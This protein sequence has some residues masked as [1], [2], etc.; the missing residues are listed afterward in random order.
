M[1]AVCKHCGASIIWVSTHTG[2]RLPLDD[3]PLPRNAPTGW[4]LDGAVARPANPSRDHSIMPRYQNHWAVC[5]HAHDG[6]LD[7]RAEAPSDRP[8]ARL[9]V[10]PWRRG[11]R[12]TTTGRVDPS[13][14]CLVTEVHL[15]LAWWPPDPEEPIGDQ[16]A[17]ELVEALRRVD[18]SVIDAAAADL[19]KRVNP[20]T[21]IIRSGAP[22]SYLARI[23]F[24][25]EMRSVCV[26][27]VYEVGSGDPESCSLQL[28]RDGRITWRRD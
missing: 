1:T 26:G 24:R 11:T 9:G 3:R 2:R 20:G 18:R 27:T 8:R 19:Q 28:H 17:R 13:Q 22:A 6:G 14:E 4:V 5:T 25:Q 16:R 7:H 23:R 12:P 15:N 21:D 10:A